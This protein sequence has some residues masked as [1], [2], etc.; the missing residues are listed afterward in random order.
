[1]LLGAEWIILVWRQLLNETGFVADN[2]AKFMCANCD[3]GSVWVLWSGKKS[4][5]HPQAEQHRS[6]CPLKERFWRGEG[7]LT[8]TVPVVCKPRENV[9]GS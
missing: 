9:E 1:M 5:Q 2:M 8:I 7:V 4:T 6:I 3:N